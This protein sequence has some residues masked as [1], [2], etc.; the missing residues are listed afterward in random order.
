VS[1]SFRGNEP[2]RESIHTVFLYYA[3]REGMSM[4]IVNA[5]QLGVYAD[6]DPVLRDLIEDVVLDRAQPVGIKY[7]Q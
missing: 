1:F 7:D 5:G 2:M 6:I 4:G 3:I